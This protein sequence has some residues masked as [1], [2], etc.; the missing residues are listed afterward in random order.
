MNIFFD[1]LLI[2]VATYIVVLAYRRIIFQDNCSIA[3]YVLLVIYI[4]CV[5]PIILNY[6]IGIPEYETVYWY[7]PFIEPMHNKIVALIYDLYIFSFSHL[8]FV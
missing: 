7:K 3:N 6:F 2:L 1:W 4:F 5:L 8:F